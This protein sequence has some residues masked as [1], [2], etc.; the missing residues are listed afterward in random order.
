MICGEIDLSAG[1]VFALAPFI[2]H[3]AAEA[4]VADVIVALLL[5]L[6]AA[7]WSAW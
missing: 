2:M 1:M 5:G 3:F 6:L 7:G 4:G